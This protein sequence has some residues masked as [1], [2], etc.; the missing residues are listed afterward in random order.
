M[1]WLLSLIV[2]VEMLKGGNQTAYVVRDGD[3][4]HRSRGPNAAT[5]VEILIALKRLHYPFAPRYRGLD[6]EGHDMLS[7]VPGA[8][9]SHPNERAEESYA[10]GARMLRTLHDL[11]TGHELAGGGECIV[12]GDPGPFNTIFGETGMPVAFIDWDSAGPGQRL[13]DVA[14]F[15]WTWCIQAVGRVD[16]VDQARRLAAVRDGYGLDRDVD[17]IAAV[18]NSQT[19]MALASTR[20]LNRPGHDDGYYR[21]QQAVIDWATADREVIRQNRHVFET[22]ITRRTLPARS[23]SAPQ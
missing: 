16:P 3:T 19:Q 11:T 2:V 4:V 7:F 5:A 17:F 10:A 8:T 1:T 20:L 9:T 14:Y 6:S 13:G 23:L 15:G 21:R 18:I 12:H 22:A